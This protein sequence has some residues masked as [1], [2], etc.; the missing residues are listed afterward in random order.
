[1]DG[2]TT[3]GVISFCTLALPAL[4]CC[5]A[6]RLRSKHVSRDVFLIFILVGPTTGLLTLPLAP[7]LDIVSAGSLKPVTHN[8]ARQFTI[9]GDLMLIGLPFSYLFGG[10]QA[11]AVGTV[12]MAWNVRNNALPWQIPLITSVIVSIAVFNGFGLTD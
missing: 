1:M 4:G 11:A 6:C 2:L 12:S 10:I 3:S 7:L 8:P 5:L 9:I